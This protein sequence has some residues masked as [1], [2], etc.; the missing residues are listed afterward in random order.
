M[1]LQRAKSKLRVAVV[2]SHPVQYYGPLFRELV[3]TIDLEVFFAHRASPAEQARAGFGEAFEWDSDPVSGYPS[4]FLHN[5]AAR[6]DASRFLGCDV[7][8]I[9][10]RLRA[11]RFDA[12]LMTGWALKAYI[13]SL[14]AAKRLGLPVVVRGDSHLG[15]PRS[16]L[17]RAIKSGLYPALLRG[18]DAAAYVGARSRAYYEH[19]HY[20]AERLFFSPHCVDTAW[21]AARATPDARQT[22]RAQLGIGPEIKLVLFAGK[23]IGRKRPLDLVA[24]AALCRAEGW[25]VEVLVAGDGALRGAMVQAAHLSKTPLHIL[26]FCNQTRMPAVYA[27]ADCLALPSEVETW[28]LVANEALACNLPIIVTNDC[29]CMADFTRD[30][31]ACLAYPTGD[32]DALAQAIKVMAMA[33]TDA[34]RLLSQKYSLAAAAAGLGAAL[35]YVTR[36]R[37]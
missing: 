8:E 31:A 14:V 17:K 10:A 3:K 35:T 15:T 7:P 18:F 22:L 30:D 29:G 16:R 21:F 25:P 5:V 37:P 26:G 9:Y 24:A 1:D 36:R 34:P 27:A 6:P 13:Q 12:L 23:L 28:G 19:Y 2:T 20:P 33:R 4:Q 11:G 32:V